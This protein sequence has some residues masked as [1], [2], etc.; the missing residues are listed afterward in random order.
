MFQDLSGKFEKILKKVKGQGKITEK[1]IRE[2]MR[3]IRRALLEADVNYKVVKKFIA[4]VEEKSLGTEVAKSITPGQLIVKIVHD[5]LTAIMGETNQ[6]IQLKGNPA[7]LM[8]VGLQGAG[9]TTLAGKL[10]AKFVEEGKK[11]KLVAADIYRPA[12]REQLRVVAE[13][14]GVDYFTLEE[15]DAVKIVK[16]A[17][18]SARLSHDVVILD[19]AGRLQIDEVLMKELDN[20]RKAVQP[21]EILFVAD[22][23]TGQDAINSAN[24]FSKQIDFTGVIL[25]KMDGDSRGGAALSIRA[26]TGKPIKYLSTGEKMDALEPFH[27]ERMAS[28][29]LG[30]GDIVSLVEKAQSAVSVEE[31]KKMQRKMR[32]Q[33]FNFED[34]Y[35]QLQ[36]IKKMGPIDQLLGMIPGMGK[37]MQGL[38]V[39]D[40]MFS[41]VEAIINSMTLKERREPKIINGSRRKRIAM[42]SGKT[43]Q[44]VNQLLKQFFEMQKLM[45]NMTAGKKLGRMMPGQLPFGMTRTN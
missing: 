9:K 11:V 6:P 21:A 27:P 24:E 26:V 5:E 2:S 15:N 13:K 23:M 1:N 43:V 19:T 42:G 37:Q 22:G 33:Q 17:V 8:L 45:K 38:S 14:T 16:Q 29:I 10:A 3:E 30:M 34:F 35:S 32:R 18:L 44:E 25:T 12:A 4:I 7:V 36:T 20:I 39:D 41:G 40:D 31:A 28:R